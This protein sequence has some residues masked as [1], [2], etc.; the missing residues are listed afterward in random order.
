MSR[1]LLFH[2]FIVCTMLRVL[3]CQGVYCVLLFFIL[4]SYSLCCVLCCIL[5]FFVLYSFILCGVFSYS[6]C[7]VLLLFVLCSLILCQRER[8][9]V[10]GVGVHTFICLWTKKIFESYFS[11]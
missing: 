10:I 6:L 7:C 3:I 9:K 8:G 4:C 1:S 11:H 5:L 2:V